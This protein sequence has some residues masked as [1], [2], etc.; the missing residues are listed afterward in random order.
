M[1]N[2]SI[3]QVAMTPSSS[4]DSLL[5]ERSEFMMSST[6]ATIKKSSR[7]ESSLSEDQSSSSSPST[8]SEADT[9][10]TTEA[11]CALA[12][13]PTLPII[14]ILMPTLCD[15]P[16]LAKEHSDFLLANESGKEACYFIINFFNYLDCFQFLFTLIIISMPE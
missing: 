10:S 3:T 8:P 1:S 9:S 15:G 2:D 4:L 14:H 12:Q 13:V 5:S 7:S 16:C 6:N 11:L